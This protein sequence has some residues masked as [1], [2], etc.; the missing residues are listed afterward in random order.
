MD[1][2]FLRTREK[3]P[4]LFAFVQYPDSAAAS[5]ENSIPFHKKSHMSGCAIFAGFIE[6]A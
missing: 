6:V 2:A 4:P 1:A 5:A 3:A